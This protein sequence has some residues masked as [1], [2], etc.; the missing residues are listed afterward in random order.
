MAEPETPAEQAGKRDASGRFLPG[1]TGNPG[2]LP[3]GVR[4]LR[5]L[6]LDAAPDAMAKCIE[7]MTS[8]DK[9]LAMFGVERVL[10]RA[11]GKDGKLAD[12]PSPNEPAEE[13]PRELTTG[14][15]LS[16]ARRTVGA[17]VQERMKAALA[18]GATAEDLH[19]MTEAMRV[20][21]AIEKE[22]REQKKKDEADQLPTEEVTRRVLDAMPEEELEAALRR[23][24][25]AASTP[26]VV[27][28]VKP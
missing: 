12:L 5:K 27:E 15:I 13:P 17:M 20:L 25:L 28:E 18:G 24:R 19:Q 6:A 16:M 1:T 26:A 3:K 11:M 22:D 9:D 2:G 7:W 23:R 8:P 4:E 14:A 10:M 21:S